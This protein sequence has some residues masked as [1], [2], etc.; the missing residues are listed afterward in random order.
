MKGSNYLVGREIKNNTI[1]ENDLSKMTRYYVSNNGVDLIKK[2]DPL[3][4]NYLTETDK[5]KLK[6][7]TNQLNIFD[8]G[9]EDVKVDPEDREENLESGH[10]CTVFNQYIK[11]NYDL[12]YDYY[13]NE[14]NKIINS[15]N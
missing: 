11:D 8:F 14:C 7:G 5:F 9:I 1:V 12:N 13:I 3:D 10:K 2:M 15:I 6:T 4:K